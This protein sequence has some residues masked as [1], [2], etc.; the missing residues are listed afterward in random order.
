MIKSKIINHLKKAVKD[1][2]EIE[3]FPPENDKFGHYST[4]VALKLAKIKRKNPLVIAEEIV[5]KLNLISHFSF[6]IS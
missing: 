2:I 4:N 3:V 5:E 1:K 6:L